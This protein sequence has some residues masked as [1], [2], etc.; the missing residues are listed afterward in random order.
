MFRRLALALAVLIVLA[1]A[2][3]AVYVASR[4]R[5]HFNAPE[6]QIAAST[7]TAVVA[8]GHYVVRVVG[9]C[10]ACH[11]APDQRQAYAEGANVPL[12]GGFEFKIPPG[13]F[14]VRNITPDPETGIGAISDGRIARALRSGVGHDGRALLPFMEMQGL[15]DEDL[16]AAISYLRSQAPVRHP[17]PDHHYNLLGMIV[18]ATVLANPVGPKSPPPHQSPRGA[19]VENGRYLAGSVANCWA[20]HTRRDPNTG[21]LTGVLYGGNTELADDFDPKRTWH[22]PNLTPDPKT[23]RSAIY[24]EDKFVARFRAG[25]VIPGSPMPWQAFRLMTDDDIRAIYRFLRTLPPV[26]N[27]VGQPFV[28][29]H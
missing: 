14:R 8:R 1:G 7:D 18:R 4:Q 5:L 2:A 10:A 9:N 16:A 29:K 17:V 12:S 6:P 13:E 27:D 23:G 25:R 3:F 24:T 15:S 20:C 26:E 21:E 19:T 22:P 11:G 28:D